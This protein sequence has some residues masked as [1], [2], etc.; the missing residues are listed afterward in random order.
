MKDKD[1]PF[2]VVIW[3]TAFLFLISL[4]S[5]TILAKCS[6]II[7]VILSLV[8]YVCIILS[9]KEISNEKRPEKIIS[10]LVFYSLMFV[11]IF[12]IGFS[13]L[14]VVEPSFYEYQINDSNGKNKWAPIEGHFIFQLPTMLYFS[15]NTATTLG[16]GDIIP[17]G[18][19][20]RFLAFLEVFFGPVLLYF[21]F[22]LFS[23]NTNNVIISSEQ[24]EGLVSPPP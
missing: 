10:Y 1:W 6:I 19:L 4:P 15:A 21:L 24:S 17:Q 12:A 13:N 5:K 20:A 3:L 2:Y 11:T 23:T 14:G 8:L 22:S 7:V 9:S 16:C 18:K